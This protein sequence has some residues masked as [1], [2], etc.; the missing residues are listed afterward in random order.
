MGV[1]FHA[2]TPPAATGTW[3]GDPGADVEKARAYRSE[4]RAARLRW[5]Q[6]TI[7]GDYERVGNK[8]PHWD[9]DVRAAYE[10][11]SHAV[12]QEPDSA[13]RAAAGCKDPLVAYC[14]LRLGR[15]P[16]APLAL[17]QP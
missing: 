7:L 9:A 12:V 10:E 11:F 16:P 1:A 4:Q 17:A 13:A 2:Q 6:A 5:K 14:A 15:A 8:N 3:L